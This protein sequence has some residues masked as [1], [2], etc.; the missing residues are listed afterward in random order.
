MLIRRSSRKIRWRDP[1]WWLG[2]GSTFL[3]MFVNSVN[4]NIFFLLASCK[5]FNV[6]I[7]MFAPA[8]IFYSIIYIQAI[9]L[10]L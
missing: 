10:F 3:F 1:V 8:Y 5:C 9:L 6:F 2:G 4:C 7:F